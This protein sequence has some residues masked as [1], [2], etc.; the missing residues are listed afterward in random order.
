M[1]AF[2]R[3][4]LTGEPT[5]FTE[6]S[7]RLGRWYTTS[8][9]SPWPGQIAM[10]LLDITQQKQAEE[11]AREREERFRLLH[12]TMLQGVVYQDAAGTIIAMNPAAERILGKGP[13]DF[14]GSSSVAV[15][16]ETLREDGTAFPGL[17]HP[18]MVALR[19]GKQVPDVLMHVYNPR[20]AR[21]RV[22]D[23]PGRAA[24]PPR[25]AEAVPGL[26]GVRRR[27]RA[28]A[29]RRGAQAPRGDA[30]PLPRRHRGL[31]ARGHDR[32]L[33]PRCRGALRLLRSGGF[34][35]QASHELLSTVHPQPW[36]QI[37]AQ[38]RQRGRWEGEVRHHT[39][40]GRQVIVSSRHQLIRG[41]DEIE[42]V[43]ETNRDVTESV[44]AEQG[45]LDQLATTRALL[46][47]A[48]AT[49]A[50][51]RHRASA[52]RRHHGGAARQ[53]PGRDPS[54]RG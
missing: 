52:A 46:E 18:A 45:M 36:P 23:H 24:L 47:A 53:K 25:G 4:A 5:Q 41:G 54:L 39:K 21:Y 2:R 48:T 43:V 31:A 28:Q 1:D 49:A 29:G 20:E 26:H 38:L 44:R 37:E 40:D 3:V 17:E 7:V 14:L 27:H 13:E 15:E 33:E 16:H 35:G 6:Y 34:F 22:I 10:I 32:E 50:F 19:T 9:F 12:D 30:R 42:R 11:A 51:D 8:I